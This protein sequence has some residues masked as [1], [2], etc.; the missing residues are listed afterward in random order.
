MVTDSHE[1]Y[2]KLKN[3]SWHLR[4]DQCFQ[5]NFRG[6]A[7]VEPVRRSRETILSAGIL[8]YKRWIYN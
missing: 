1:M 3:I 8:F 7:L 5:E 2:E 6:S 4:A